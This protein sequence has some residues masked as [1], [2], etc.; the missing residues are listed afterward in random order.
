MNRLKK[1]FTKIF[2][3]DKLL[4]YVLGIYIALLTLPFIAWWLSLILVFFVA[5]IIEVND[6]V[7]KKGTP[8]IL[9][10]IYTVMG[11]GSV[12][13]LDLLKKIAYA[14]FN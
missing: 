4:H 2:P 11:G 6:K 10:I 13:V 5:L 12:I 8:E 3:Y 9:D 14:I 1:I 7:N